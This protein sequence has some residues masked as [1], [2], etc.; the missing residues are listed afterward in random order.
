MAKIEAVCAIGNKRKPSYHPKHGGLYRG[1]M[2]SIEE[3]TLKTSTL[4]ITKEEYEKQCR[5][6]SKENKDVTKKTKSK[7]N[8]GGDR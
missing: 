4:F 6:V 8:K 1:R 7:F 5:E 2:V 3:A